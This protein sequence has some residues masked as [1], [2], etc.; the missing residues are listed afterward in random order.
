MRATDIR[1]AIP[2]VDRQLS[3]AEASRVIADSG[4][5]GVV[6]SDGSGEPI[7]VITALDVLRL[8]LPDYLV[9]DSSLAATLDEAAIEEMIAPLRAKS[10]AEVI[11]DQ[12]VT[13]HDVPTVDADATMLEIAAIL[14]SAGCPVAVI[15]DSVNDDRRFVTLAAVLQSVLTIGPESSGPESTDPETTGPNTVGRDGASA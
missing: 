4:K 14:V 1:I 10:L 11:G 9:D 15:S 12:A 3:V 13:V 7:G 6:V 5:T 8:A 2:M